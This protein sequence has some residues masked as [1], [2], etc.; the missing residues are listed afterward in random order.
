MAHDRLYA[1]VRLIGLRRGRAG[2]EAP[3]G[4]TWAPVGA[5]GGD[6]MR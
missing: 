6:G 5:R 4:R 1:D 3:K 2:A